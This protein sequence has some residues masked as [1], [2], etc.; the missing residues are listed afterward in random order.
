VRLCEISEIDGKE[1]SSRITFG[2]LNLTH[3]K[4]NEFPELLDPNLTYNISIKLD[5]IAHVFK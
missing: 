5:D 1:E 4:S 2:M 3:Y